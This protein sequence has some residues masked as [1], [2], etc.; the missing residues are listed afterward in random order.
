MNKI[1]N[2]A[3]L[4]ET[5]ILPT[6]QSIY[7]ADS[8]IHN[9]AENYKFLEIDKELTDCLETGQIL[10]IKGSNE[11]NAVLCTENKTYDLL[12]CETSNSLLLVKGLQFH[13]VLKNQDLRQISDV[14]TFGVFYK[15]LSPVPGKPKLRKLKQ[16]L[17][18]TSYRG[19]ELEYKI[20]T[21]DLYSFEELQDVIQASNV[22][23]T[24]A[25]KDLN[26]ITINGKIRILEFEYHFRV[27]SYMMKVLDE[28]SIRYDE[29]DYE[30]TVKAL[31]EYCVPKEVIESLFYLYTEPTSDL[32]HYRYTDKVAK[33]FAQVLLV[34]AG[35]F[36][37]SE[38]L[39]AWQDSVPD[40]MPTDESMLRGIAII[41]RQANV[42][43]YFPEEDLPENVIERFNVL[44]QAKEN[45]TAEEIV[46]YIE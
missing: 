27:L 41:D 6:S 21:D 16:L 33:F 14:S 5:D 13:N 28:E 31:L 17:N 30:E 25:L 7:F 4:K 24:K 43:R 3:K 37:L 36:N 20:N 22:E 44:F 35:K 34:N 38:F 15:Y 45:W 29:V 1:L 9:C 40:G 11:E 32:K 12:E 23:L 10:Y 46:A 8:N 42:I 19:S 2:L 18:K 26:T 39:Q